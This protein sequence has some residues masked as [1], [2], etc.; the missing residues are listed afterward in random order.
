[1]C[2]L[3]YR[4]ILNNLQKHKSEIEIRPLEKTL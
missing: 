4:L 2:F 1:M 3:F